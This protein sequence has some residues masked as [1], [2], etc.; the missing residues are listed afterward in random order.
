VCGKVNRQDVCIWGTKNLHATVDH[1]PDSR[2][3]NVSFAVSSCKVYGSFFFAEPTV[4]GTNYLDMV[5][6]WLMAQLQEDSEDFTLQQAGAPPHFHYDIRAHLNANLPGCQIGCTSDNDSPLLPWPP[7][8]PDLT[9]CDFS[10]WVTSRIVCMCPL[11]HMI[12]HS[13]DKGSWK[14]SLLSTMRCCNMCGMTI[15][16]SYYVMDLWNANK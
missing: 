13:C 2:K 11:C 1:I 3:V 12:H 16:I 4:T 10:Y 14:Q 9:P 6:L 7:Q 15:S 8:S 5:Q